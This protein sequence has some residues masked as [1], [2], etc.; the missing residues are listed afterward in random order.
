M[1]R[2]ADIYFADTKYFAESMYHLFYQ[3]LRRP[4]ILFNGGAVPLNTFIQY[5]DSLRCPIV[6]VTSDG[7]GNYDNFEAYRDFV[8]SKFG[9]N[10]ATEFL[11]PRTLAVVEGNDWNTFWECYRYLVCEFKADIIGIPAHLEFDPPDGNEDTLY[12][13]IEEADAL[14]YSF[15]RL[16]VVKYLISL[17][18]VLLPNVS[19]R[20]LKHHLLGLNTPLEVSLF[21]EHNRYVYSVNT[22]LPLIAALNGLTLFT[23]NKDALLALNNTDVSLDNLDEQA[24][25]LYKL[26]LR[27]LYYMCRTGEE[28]T[29]EAQL[30]TV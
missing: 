7:T 4:V 11:K 1:S 29:S 20:P 10:R 27:T 3:G 22:D 15:R 23:E 21:A 9:W 5:A 30:L 17:V 18:E 25:T 12:N 24:V 13:Y 14:K 8:R 6:V 16:R 2:S 28:V 19:D 26:N